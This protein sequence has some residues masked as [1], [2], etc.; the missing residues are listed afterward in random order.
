MLHRNTEP[1]PI[2]DSI[3]LDIIISDNHEEISAVLEPEDR[4]DT[5]YACVSRTYFKK[6]KDSTPIKA[7][8]VILMTEFSKDT[9]ITSDI[10]VHEAVH[11]KNKLYMTLGIKNDRNNDE[12]EAYLMEWIFKKI[13]Q[14]FEI[15]NKLKEN[16]KSN[17]TSD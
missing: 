1:F 10:I 6:D 9:R 11:V 17:T 8:T 7:V 12:P 15:Y 13:S 14:E 3:L 16:G 4:D 2:Y 5:Y